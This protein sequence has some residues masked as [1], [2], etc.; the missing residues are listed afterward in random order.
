M[1]AN[2]IL[3]RLA[4]FLILLSLMCLEAAAQPVS[5]APAPQTG[6]NNLG[7]ESANTGGQADT[8]SLSSQRD[9]RTRARNSYVRL[10]RAPHMFGDTLRPSATLSFPQK[11]PQG[12]TTPTVDLPLGGA[13]SY[14]VADN[15]SAIPMDRVYF[16]YN[17]FFN[18]IDS[19]VPGLGTQ[20][21]DLHMYRIGLE[22]TFLDGL[23]SLDLRMPFTSNYDLRTPLVSTDSGTIGNLSMFLKRLVFKNDDMAMA[24]GL[25]IGLPTGNDVVV[26]TFTNRSTIHNDAVH[27]MPYVALMATPNDRWFI[28]SF[29]QIDFAASG[30]EV[31]T[32]QGTAGVYTEQNLMHLDVGLGRWL[33]QPM[34]YRYLRG[35]ASVFELHYTSTLQD[36]DQINSLNAGRIQTIQVPGNHTDMLNLTSGLHFQLTPAANLRVGAVAPLRADPNRVFD[37]EIYVSFNRFF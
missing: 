10:A 5:N 37:S 34:G 3:K 15:N 23:W 4:F 31:V 9:A 12:Q 27:L 35:I 18:A 2:I 13:G 28:Q 33:G 7:T 26:T 8:S 22:K 30:N 16:L 6:S 21:T 25:G 14:N 11:D 24:S 32:P 20:S 1:I 19:S 36:S 17:G 29:A